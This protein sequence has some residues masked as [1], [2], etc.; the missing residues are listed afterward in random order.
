MTH[1]GGI[2]VGPDGSIW[3]TEYSNNSIGRLTWD[4]TVFAPSNALVEYPVP[5]PGDMPYSDPVDIT[6]GPNG[7]LWFTEPGRNK[8]GE[9]AWLT[10]LPRDQDSTEWDVAT[11]VSFDPHGNVVRGAWHIILGP[12]GNLWFTEKDTNHLWRFD[13]QT[14]QGMPISVP[15]PP[16]LPASTPQDLRGITAGLGSLWITDNKA[17]VIYQVTLSPPTS[18]SFTPFTL[19]TTALGHPED[20]TVAPNGHLW[21]TDQDTSNDTGKIGELDPTTG[22]VIE[23]PQQTTIPLPESITVDQNG[24]LW[25]TEPDANRI[26][27]LDPTTHTITQP[28]GLQ[29]GPMTSPEGITVDSK[30]NIWFTETDA[31]KIGEYRFGCAN[32]VYPTH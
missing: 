7:L 23:Y 8:I 20:I 13:P 5:K 31:N 15:L 30:G 17:G 14:H 9:L 29:F 21:F 10:L 32:P 12:D 6:V 27:T 24:H 16:N 18:Q 3:F 28:Q 25:F 19:P 22:N 26:E 4:K 11:Q 1:P 2:I